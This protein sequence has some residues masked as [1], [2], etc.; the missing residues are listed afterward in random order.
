LGEGRLSGSREVDAGREA[1]SI[2]PLGVKQRFPQ[3]SGDRGGHGKGTCQDEGGGHRYVVASKR[4]ARGVTG[5]KE[6][7]EMRI[8]RG[9]HLFGGASRKGSSKDSQA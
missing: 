2:T 1:G 9:V 6:V 8:F 3:Q 4:V 5:G 7:K